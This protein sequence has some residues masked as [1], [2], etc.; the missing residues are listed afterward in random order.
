MPIYV[1][2]RRHGGDETDPGFRRMKASGMTDARRIQAG[3]Q[4]NLNHEKY[5]TTIVER[6]ADEGDG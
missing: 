2:I 6:P 5:F 3:A 1:A 4:I